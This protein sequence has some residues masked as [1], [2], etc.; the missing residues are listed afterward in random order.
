MLDA[1][2]LRSGGV[3]GRP[4]YYLMPGKQLV[5]GYLFYVRSFALP[6]QGQSVDIEADL[7]PGKSYRMNVDFDGSDFSV[8]VEDTATG[9]RVGPA[10]R[11]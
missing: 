6:P 11:I 4:S 7:E 9:R 1:V 2:R 8:W 10:V 3:F 5:L